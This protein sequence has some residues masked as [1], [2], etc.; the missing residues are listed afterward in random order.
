MTL[1]HY[2]L[3]KIYFPRDVS[4]MEFYVSERST[5]HNAYLL[6]FSAEAKNG[7]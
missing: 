4:L 7:Q 1:N 5:Q 3:K 2:I 6:S